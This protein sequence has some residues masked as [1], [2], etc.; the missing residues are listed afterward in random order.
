[1]YS[2]TESFINQL[3]EIGI[4]YSYQGTYEN[5]D[6]IVV[7]I[8]DGENAT[9]MLVR[10]FFDPNEE[11]VRL[12]VFDFIKFPASKTPEMLHE[13]NIVNR[14]YRMAKFTIDPEEHS[15]D[16][17][18]DGTFR[19]DSAG[20]VT[21]EMLMCCMKVCDTAYPYFMKAIWK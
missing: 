19:G 11:D 15:V 20:E 8:F 13:I 1:M 12:C 16:V 7:V 4:K 2:S 21:L 6:D 10:V 3:D 5:G 17:Y 9:N 18:L 14:Q